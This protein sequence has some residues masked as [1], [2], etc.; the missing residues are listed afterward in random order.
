M[1]SHGFSR[2]YNKHTYADVGV[3]RRHTAG[4]LASR[5]HLA[6][7]QPFSEV[8]KGATRNDKE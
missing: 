1:T 4:W 2:E 7:G 8:A 5:Y 3:A 6:A